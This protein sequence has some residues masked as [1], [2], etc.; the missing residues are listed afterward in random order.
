LE[1]NVLAAVRERGT[2]HPKE[3]QEWFGRGR[4]TNAWGGI[5]HAT[6]T[7]LEHLHYAG[8]I[9]VARRQAGVRVYESPAPFAFG[10]PLS[11]RERLGKVVSLLVNVLAPVREGM[12]NALS[13]RLRR[14]AA[15]GHDHREVLRGLLSTGELLRRDVDGVSYILPPAM[16]MRQAPREVKFL[17]PFDPL[18]WDRERFEQLWGWQYRFEAYTPSVKRVRGYNALPLLWGP[19]VIAWVNVRVAAG[20]D[21]AAGFVEKQP[22]ERAFRDAFEAEVERLRSFLGD[23]QAG[24]RS[25]RRQ[26]APG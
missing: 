18:V 19:A 16:R 25:V 22:R 24:N 7:A 26:S 20:L 10:E 8:L 12:L 3:L 4:V 9:R 6:T 2:L 21:V 11:E 15:P 17:A 14:H 5:S 23:A 13:A 1:R